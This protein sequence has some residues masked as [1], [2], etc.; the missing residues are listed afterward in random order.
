[1]GLDP[2]MRSRRESLPCIGAQGRQANICHGAT[3]I[4][5][6]SW[7]FWQDQKFNDT[8]FGAKVLTGTDG[9]S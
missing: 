9:F 7:L 2:P 5:S 6:D 8:G 3:L 1:M 4:R